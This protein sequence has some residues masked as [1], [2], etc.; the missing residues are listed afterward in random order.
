ML[1]ADDSCEFSKDELMKMEDDELT[2]M[3]SNLNEGFLNFFVN[4][5]NNIEKGGRGKL[6]LEK[7][8][9]KIKSLLRLGKKGDKRGLSKEPTA[10]EVARVTS[11]A[12]KDGYL[13]RVSVKEGK[14]IYINSRDSKSISPNTTA[15]A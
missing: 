5:V 4:L 12:D 9:N 6:W 15:G 7:L 1:D 8:P 13:G 11:E 10:D 14:L 3:C 2:D